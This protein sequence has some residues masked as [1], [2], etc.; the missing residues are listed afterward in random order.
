M[1]SGITD[2]CHHTQIY[3]FKIMDILILEK[4]IELRPWN[5][6]HLISEG[7]IDPSL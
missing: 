3:Y 2:L 1:S 4:K 6:Y 7:G 5:E